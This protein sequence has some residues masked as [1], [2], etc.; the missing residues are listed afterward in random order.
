[1]PNQPAQPVYPALINGVMNYT[2]D[3]EHYSLFP[4]GVTSYTSTAAFA[5]AQT[6][7]VAAVGSTPAN[8]MLIFDGIGVAPSGLQPSPVTSA[9]SNTNAIG[10]YNL[11][12][13]SYLSLS[14]AIKGVINN[15]PRAGRANNNCRIFWFSDSTGGGYDSLVASNHYT[16][17][18]QQ[19]MT[20]NVSQILNEQV[21]KSGYQSHY[22]S[23]VDWHSGGPGQSNFS[24]SDPRMANIAGSWSTFNGGQNVFSETYWLT[25]VATDTITFTP[26]LNTTKGI[27]AATNACDFSFLYLSA[28]DAALS[29]KVNGTTAST[30]SVFSGSATNAYV[31][32]QAHKITGITGTAATGNAYQLAKSAASNTIFLGCE[33]YDSNNAEISLI[34]C[35]IGSTVLHLGTGSYGNAYLY[36]PAPG[37]WYCGIQP[38]ING[39]AAN[40]YNGIASANP[41]AI[42]PDAV[43]ISYGINHW[44]V[45]ASFTAAAFQSALDATVAAFLNAS[46]TNGNVS[47]PVILVTPAPSP[48]SAGSGANAAAAQAAQLAYIQAYQAVSLKYGVVLIDPWNYFGASNSVAVSAGWMSVSD[49]HP[50][51]VG[52]SLVAQLFTNFVKAIL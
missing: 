35:S 29:V 4:G 26:S 43:V 32:S 24:V 51:P 27:G 19:A 8:P 30:V 22:G 37:N 40:G 23:A 15:Y 7:G 14:N 12:K 46:L 1:M 39:N 41:S 47:V 31:A 2:A 3:N 50:Y 9:V 25:N 42:I 10:I 11:N 49:V 16:N 33:A 38:L 20:T 21:C 13:S 6:P 36:P 52:Y 44:D 48:Y 34:N 45:P 28:Y 17:S 18:Y 5:A